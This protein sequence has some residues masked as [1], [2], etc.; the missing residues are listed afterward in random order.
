MNT[1]SGTQAKNEE[2]NMKKRRNAN[3]WSK[4]TGSVIA[5]HRN[6]PELYSLLAIALWGGYLSTRRKIAISVHRM[7]NMVEQR[8]QKFKK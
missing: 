8:T 7:R 2:K 6:T 1:R 4:Q 5:D 3:L